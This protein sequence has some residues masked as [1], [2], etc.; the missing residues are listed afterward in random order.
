MTAKADASLDEITAHAHR[1][2]GKLS[3]DEESRLLS[4]FQKLPKE[5]RRKTLSV[6]EEQIATLKKIKEREANRTKSSKS[7][8]AT[9]IFYM[10]VS[11]FVGAVA[12]VA[13]TQMRAHDTTSTHTNVDL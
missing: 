13:N 4:G 11:I 2:Q 12:Y 1:P 10:T 8:R 9:L 6:L 7:T 3:K 5:Q